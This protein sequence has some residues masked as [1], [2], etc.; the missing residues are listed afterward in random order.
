MK[1]VSLF[2]VLALLVMACVPDARNNDMVPDSFGTTATNPLLQASIHSGYYKI[3]IAK[4]GKG[5]SAASA[6]ISR[7]PADYMA[8]LE[9][10]NQKNGTEYTPLP[11]SY[12]TLDRTELHYNAEEVVQEVTL[13][14][15]PELVAA[16]M[17]E[18]TNW[19]IPLRLLSNDLSVNDSH[20]FLMVRLTRSNLSVSQQMQVRSIDR[21]NVEPDAS[22]QQPELKETITLDLVN[23]NPVKGVGLS[24]PVV[25]DNSLIETFNESQG[26]KYEQ[27]PEGLVNILTPTVQIPEGG[28][29]ASFRIVLDKEKLLE[30]GKLKDFPAYVIPVRV[31]Q[32]GLEATLNGEPFGLKGLSYGNMVTYITVSYAQKGIS[33]ITREWGLYSA[34][35]AWYSGLEGFAE[36][37]DRTIAMD[38]DYVYVA[39]SNGT[40][41]IYALS[42][43]SGTFVKKLDVGPAA[44]NGCTFPVSCIRMVRN[45]K[46]KDI[47]TFCSL[48]ADS[49]Q[50]LFVYAYV[51]GTDAAPVQ[52]LDYLHDNAGGAD[53]WRRYGDRYTVEGN[54][55]EGTLWFMTWSDGAKGK[56]LG[57]HLS[58]GRITNPE[59]PEDYF[60]ANDPSG[61]KDI[62]RYP[63]WSNFLVTRSGSAGTYRPGNADGN[64]WT[65]LNLMD[66]LP[67]YAL[68]YGFNFFDFHDT[69]FIAY[70]KLDEENGNK[71]RL[72]VIDDNSRIPGDFP[73][74][75]KARANLREFPIQHPDSFDEKASLT[76]ASS[77]GDCAVWDISGNTYIAVLMQ[78]CGL[79]LFSLQ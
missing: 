36:G 33:G 68:C 51:N 22:G 42:R 69:N 63:G 72:V 57:F 3:G 35:N 60:V 66:N 26:K 70:M 76:A 48:K 52:I 43:S 9:A 64:G 2:T 16:I 29:S 44:G 54:W 65:Q 1:K 53:D 75:L 32:E 25:I 5:L 13:N 71:G 4:N 55:D 73:A 12:Y 11:A 8:A 40:P 59:D 17:G 27:A 18:Q 19:V 74:Q 30:N 79:S 21:K 20:N 23:N 10:Y 38:D 14:W 45:P 31:K 37:A 78:G 50:D 39:H 28:T 24:F 56:A 47:L 77:V 67:E 34:G 62:V 41:A 49:D 58:G 6:R 61:I 46:G 7:D 15:D